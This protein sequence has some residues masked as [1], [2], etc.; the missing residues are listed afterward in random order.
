[1]TEDN[2]YRRVNEAKELAKSNHAKRPDL[3]TILFFDEANTTSA[4]GLVKE[5][6]CDHRVCGEPLELAS[7][8]LQI[9]AACNPYRK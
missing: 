2:I 4:I 8:G 6:M 3:E 9:V 1:M 5:I 7:Y